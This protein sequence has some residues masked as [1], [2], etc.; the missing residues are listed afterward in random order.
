V[1]PQ[2]IEYE[3]TI[4]DTAYRLDMLVDDEI[5]VELK[6]VDRILPIHETQLLSYLRLSQRPLGLLINFRVRLLKDGIRRLVNRL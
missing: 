5:I 6:T 4:L 1:V 3:G 2:P